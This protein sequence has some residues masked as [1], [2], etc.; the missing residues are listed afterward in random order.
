MLFPDTFN[1]SSIPNFMKQKLPTGRNTTSNSP[2]RNVQDFTYLII[3]IPI[4][5][6]HHAI[7]TTR[8][9]STSLYYRHQ[10]IKI[11]R[12]DSTVKA[13]VFFYDINAREA[14]KSTSIISD[15]IDIPNHNKT[16]RLKRFRIC[17]E[18]IS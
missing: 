7:N 18:F 3:R 4:S 1:Q 12:M 10:I 6:I 15:N 16:P 8:F 9:L 5:I 13:D 14:Y 17:F 2:N 11:Y